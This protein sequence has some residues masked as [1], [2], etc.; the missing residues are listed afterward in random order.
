MSDPSGPSHPS[1]ESGRSFE[2]V[3]LRQHVWILV[4]SW[5]VR[6]AVGVLA[7]YA[8]VGVWF[9]H[10]TTERGLLDPSGHPNW[11]VV[12]LGFFYLLLR[13]AARFVVPAL[14]A[15]VVVDRAARAI[16]A[17]ANAGGPR[18]RG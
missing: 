15:Y 5:S 14:L 16:V 7:A 4:R 12:L 8:I 2:R 18:A 17:L 10:E 6:Q 1:D 3:S 13:L 11:L 9:E